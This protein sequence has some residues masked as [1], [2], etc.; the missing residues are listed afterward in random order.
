MKNRAR[1]VRR[2]FILQT[3]EWSRAFPFAMGIIAHEP[4]GLESNLVL[5]PIHFQVQ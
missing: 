1:F 4:L 5:P 2:H 3:K